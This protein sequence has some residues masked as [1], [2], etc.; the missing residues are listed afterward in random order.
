MRD[1]R[2]GERG[3]SLVEIVVA[4]AIVAIAT[5]A[6]GA[7]TSAAVHRFGPDPIQSALETSAT[8]EMR[9]AVDVMKYQGA[10]LP[11]ASVATTVP[12]P[13][14]SPIP[15]SY[16]LSSQTNADS[17]VTILLSVTD[18][19]DGTKSATVSQTIAAPAPLPGARVPAAG[20]GSAPQ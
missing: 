2:S 15:V 3:E 10:S 11:I 20:N 4:I 16:A 13:S 14:G 8:R 12:L 1:V 19:D 17:S 9:V 6:L 18:S 5:G 7:A